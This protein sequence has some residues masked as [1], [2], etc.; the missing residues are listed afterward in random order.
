MPRP[1]LIN[2]ERAYCSGTDD[3]GAPSTVFPVNTLLTND[4]IVPPP[5]DRPVPLLVIKF[6][7]IRIAP[8]AEDVIPVVLCDIVHEFTPRVAD[9]A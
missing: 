2:D 1:L 6:P 8:P 7:M 3:E 5:S 9:A 4:V